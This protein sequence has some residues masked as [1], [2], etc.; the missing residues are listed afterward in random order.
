MFRPGSCLSRCFEGEEL[1]VGG[2]CL[3]NNWE[4]ALQVLP[5]LLQHK[6]Q[7][8]QLAAHITQRWVGGK[9]GIFL[10][11]SRV[12]QWELRVFRFGMQETILYIFL[13]L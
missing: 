2:S 13:P 8:L 5:L 6:P 10:T 9:E 12:P 4:W 3:G 11:P 7:V 1:S